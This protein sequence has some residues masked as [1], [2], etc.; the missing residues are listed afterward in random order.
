MAMCHLWG[1][2]HHILLFSSE[3]RGQLWA[4]CMEHGQVGAPLLHAAGKMQ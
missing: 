3:N 1:G 4:S 2:T